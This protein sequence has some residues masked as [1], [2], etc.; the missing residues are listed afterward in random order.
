MTDFV[1]ALTTLPANFDAEALARE[2]VGARVA[3]CVSIG[4]PVKSV[5]SW[6]GEIE[7]GH[8]QQLAIKT[9]RHRTEALWNALRTRHPYDVPEFIVVPI[10]DGN[11]GYLAWIKASVAE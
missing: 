6:K 7:V 9:S 4:P 3:A 1:L 5:Y 10:T 2:L 8:E 11:P